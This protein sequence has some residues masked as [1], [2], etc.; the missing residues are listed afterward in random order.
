[1]NTIM[2]TILISLASSAFLTAAVD[3]PESP[4]R[5]IY[6]RKSLTNDP[7]IG[8]DALDSA[9]EYLLP[10][11]SY[12]PDKIACYYVFTFHNQYYNLA[13]KNIKASVVREALLSQSDRY[14]LGELNSSYLARNAVGAYD[15]FVRAV[16]GR[17]AAEKRLI[18]TVVAPEA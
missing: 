11:Q 3:L 14:L 16:T 18:L 6:T 15:R 17:I 9:I 10:N 12:D 8:D 2:K 1:M 5:V 4:E 7:I 13:D